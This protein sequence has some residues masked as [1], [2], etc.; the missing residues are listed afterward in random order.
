MPAGQLRALLAGKGPRGGGGV[1][2]GRVARCLVHTLP[3]LLRGAIAGDPLGR[4]E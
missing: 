2:R 1:Q 4:D 3:E